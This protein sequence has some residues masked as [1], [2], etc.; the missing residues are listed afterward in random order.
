MILDSL[1]LAKLSEK[2]GQDV[3]TPAGASVLQLDIESVTGESLSLNTVRRLVGVIQSEKLTP[4]RTTLNIIAND[5]GLMT[6][7]I[8]D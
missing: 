6:A 1:I 7:G 2:I 8:W 5:I 4:R 3:T